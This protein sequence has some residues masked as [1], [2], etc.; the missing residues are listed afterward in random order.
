MFII[1]IIAVCARS[2]ADSPAERAVINGLGN[3][4]RKKRNVPRRHA[5]RLMNSYRLASSSE[6][7]TSMSPRDNIT[8]I[9]I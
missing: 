6:P 4:V 8:Y 3:K 9:I 7:D 1:I 2:D 5:G